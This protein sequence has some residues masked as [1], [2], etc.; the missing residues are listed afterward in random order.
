MYSPRLSR[1][2]RLGTLLTLALLAAPLVAQDSPLTEPPNGP[3]RID[4]GWH[5]LVGATVHPEPGGA[6]EGATVVVRDGRIVSVGWAPPPAGARVWDLTGLHVY[7]A[8]I[9]AWVEVD[10]PRPKKGAAGEHWCPVV[11]PRRSALDGPGIDAKTAKQLRELGFA[12]AAIAPRGGVFRG[13]AALVSLAEPDPEPGADP[14]PVY[15]PRAYQAVSFE[16][17]GGDGG[18]PNSEMGAIALVRQVLLDAVWTAAGGGA[19]GGDDLPRC[20]GGERS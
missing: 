19:E 6:I 18:A 3:R 2:L 14:P 17:K 8:F 11:T 4:P 15:S 13:E 9:D 1:T 5:A 12:A 7:P 10:A 16:S 20:A